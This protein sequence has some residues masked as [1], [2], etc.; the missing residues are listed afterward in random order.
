[1]NSKYEIKEADWE[2]LTDGTKLWMIFNTFND[3]R[4]Q[5]EKRF[6]R[7]E[8]CMFAFFMSAVGAVGGKPAYLAVSKL[9]GF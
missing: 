4:T 1:M 6:R 7:I 5:A 2:K 9:L 8:Y 3:Y